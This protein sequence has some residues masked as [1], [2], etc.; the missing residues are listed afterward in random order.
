EAIAAGADGYLLKKAVSDELTRAMRE[1]MGGKP[2]WSA[3]V[4]Q[5]LFQRVRENN[6]TSNSLTDREIEILKLIAKELTSKEIA[7]R[8]FISERTVEVH[9]KNLMRKV[10]CTNT[11]GL[12]KY[13]FSKGLL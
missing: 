6:Y 10:N 5:M 13:A 1:V 9:R 3:E 8:L 4:G 2:Y 11:V 7:A 12:I